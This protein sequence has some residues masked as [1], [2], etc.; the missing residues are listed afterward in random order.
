MYMKH[1]ND[2]YNLRKSKRERARDWK[3]KIKRAKVRENERDIDW[4]ERKREILREW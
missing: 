4:K 3:R 2:T 1:K